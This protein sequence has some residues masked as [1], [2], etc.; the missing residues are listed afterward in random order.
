MSILVPLSESGFTAIYYSKSETLKVFASGN[1]PGWIIR[2]HLEREHYFVGGLKFSLLGAPGGSPPKPAQSLHA[3][4]EVNINLPHAPIHKDSV[5]C[6]SADGSFDIPVTT[7]DEAVKYPPAGSNLVPLSKRSFDAS[8]NVTTKTLSLFANGDVAGWVLGPQLSRDLD[9]VG[10]LK[11]E[12][13]GYSGGLGHQPTQHLEA[14]I[15]IEDDDFKWK[16]ATCE[17]KDGRFEVPVSRYGDDKDSNAA[18]RRKEPT[19]GSILVPLPESGFKAVYVTKTKTLT[20]FA[21]GEVPGWI[22]HP[23]LERDA[24]YGGFKFSLRGFPGGIPEAPEH[25]IETSIKLHVVLPSEHLQSRT[26]TCQSATDT[27]HIKI[28]YTGLGGQSEDS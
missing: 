7:Y 23:H 8:Y 14:S 18:T 2:P 6:E 25:H 3:V 12:L 26:V 11:F 1:I 15:A 13:R 24:L 22:L 28:N 20:V 4:I 10:G 19:P 21:A 5:T 17:T 27:Y 16:V 9:W